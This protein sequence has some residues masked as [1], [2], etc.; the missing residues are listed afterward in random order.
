[1]RTNSGM[2]RRESFDEAPHPVGMMDLGRIQ[3]RAGTRRSDGREAA[4]LIPVVQRA[5]GPHLVFTKRSDQL[6]EHPGQM[7]FPG[8]SREPSDGDRFETASREAYEEIGL[9]AEEIDHV[10]EL[11][12]IKTTTKYV[13]RPIVSRVPDRPFQ[14]DGVEIVEAPV[15]PV[16]EFLSAHNYERSLHTDPSGTE[17][18]VHSFEVGG[19]RVW[20][21]TGNLVVQL[22]E[23][24]TDW[25]AH[26][27]SD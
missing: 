11:D 27:V 1:M 15:L 14:P 13:I 6:S 8:G 23:L 24:T 17:R 12:D 16:S 5:S 9:P 26:L 3:G 10:G 22:L 2:E 7:S 4:V 21:A 19:Y 20:G 25:R 18:I